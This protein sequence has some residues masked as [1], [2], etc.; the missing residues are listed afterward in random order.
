MVSESR[1]A[2]ATCKN[3][4]ELAAFISLYCKPVCQSDNLYLIDASTDVEPQFGSMSDAHV[5]FRLKS[6]DN[7][8][9]HFGGAARLI[10][11]IGAWSL[12]RSGHKSC[13]ASVMM[14]EWAG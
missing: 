14:P 10:L 2:R 1:V 8:E 11:F 7:G 9:V 3:N 12:P 5:L 4:Y 6:R 13:V